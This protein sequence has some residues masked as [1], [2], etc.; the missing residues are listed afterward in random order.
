MIELVIYVIGIAICCV[1]GGFLLKLNIFN[2]KEFFE[3][4]PDEGTVVL[5]AL[6][7]PIVFITGLTAGCLYGLVL[8]GK[9]IGVK[10]KG[11]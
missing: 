11:T 6:A 9:A 1:L 2:D 4:P 7:W 3:E 10:K 8:L 5:L